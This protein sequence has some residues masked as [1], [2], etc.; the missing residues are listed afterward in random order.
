MIGLKLSEMSTQDLWTLY[1]EMNAELGRKIKVEKARLEERLRKVN[2]GLALTDT[3]F[4][5]QRR[6]YPKVVPKYR[7]P[8]NL[9]ETWSGRGKRPRWL[10]AQLRSGKRL[11]HFLIGRSA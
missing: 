9:N 10:A 6:P 7:N 3:N 5:R 11:N 2:S 1:E 8:N 4:G